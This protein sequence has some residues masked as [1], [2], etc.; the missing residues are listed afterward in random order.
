MP[1]FRRA[2]AEEQDA[3]AS[4]GRRA[5]NLKNVTAEIP[6]GLFTCVTGRL[7]RRQVDAPDRHALCR[8]RAHAQRRP[9][10]PRP[11]TSGSRGSNISTRSSTSTSRRSAARRAR[12]RRPIP[13][14]S[15]RSATGSPACPRPRPAATARPLLVQRQGRPLRGLP[16]RR[17]HQDRDA[18]PA[19]RLRHLRRLQ[20]QALQPRDAGDPVQGQV[21]RRR[22]RHDRRGGE[23]TSSTPC[24]PIRD[25]ME[26]LDRVGLG[27][28]HVGQQA[29]TLSGGEAQ[30]V[31]LSK[32][33]SRR[34]TGRTLYILD[35]PTTGLHFARRRQA[36]RGPPPAGRAGQH[37]GR[38]RAQSRGHQDR[39]LDHRPRP[40]GRRRRRRD[41][42]RRHARGRSSRS[43]AA[44]PASS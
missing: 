3:A 32:E 44:I 38:H 11:R 14:P 22:P 34:A 29:D 6:L 17:R 40:R 7:R 1:L 33:L 42:R 24:P 25:K 16:G 39:R 20:G 4:S 19:R 43:S 10:A 2:A 13:A 28:I 15:P 8:G 18:L 27:Y 23:A 12:T 30:R 21:H 36:P 41:R 35:E 37:G 31:K 26:T 5:N 9:R